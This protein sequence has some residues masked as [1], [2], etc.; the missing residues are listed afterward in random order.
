MYLKRH[1]HGCPVGTLGI[2][3]RLQFLLDED[4]NPDIYITFFEYNQKGSLYADE[5]QQQLSHHIQVDIWSL[6][7]YSK[8]T[9]QVKQSLIDVGFSRTMETEFYE[10]ETK[11]L[12]QG[13][14]F[15]YT[16]GT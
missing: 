16:E 4:S 15:S 3:V 2:M 11:I 1:L 6:G 5:E 9:E 10:F 8:L 7:N 14:P 12:S 13:Y